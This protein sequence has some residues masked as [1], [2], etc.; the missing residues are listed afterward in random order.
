MKYSRIVR[1][2]ESII[3]VWYSKT[4]RKE[5]AEG[6]HT[7]SRRLKRSFSLWQIFLTENRIYAPLVGKTALNLMLYQTKEIESG[8]LA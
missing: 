7:A 3:W 6:H 1:C 8:A 5:E 4:I 2:C